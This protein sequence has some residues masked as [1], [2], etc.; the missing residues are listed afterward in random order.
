MLHCVKSRHCDLGESTLE[1]ITRLITTNPLSMPR[2]VPTS[3]SSPSSPRSSSSGMD[4][5]LVHHAESGRHGSIERSL[6]HNPPRA[7]SL[8]AQVRQD[9]DPGQLC[10]WPQQWLQSGFDRYTDQIANETF[11]SYN[12]GPHQ[13]TLVPPRYRWTQYDCNVNDLLEYE[14]TLRPNGFSRGQPF[15]ARADHWREMNAPSPSPSTRMYATPIHPC[16]PLS[17]SI[18]SDSA[19]VGDDEDEDGIDD[20]D[21]IDEDGIPLPQDLAQNHN[22]GGN[23]RRHRRPWTEPESLWLLQCV[24]R[25]TQEIEAEVFR[26]AVRGKNWNRIAQMVGNGRTPT[27][28]SNKYHKLMRETRDQVYTSG[29][30]TNQPGRV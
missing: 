25:H 22:R 15:P 21:A 20:D 19:Y 13:H 24:E 7:F 18:Q 11:R 5:E 3:S 12:V 30:S 27:S 6:L 1:A 4:D 29:S 28:C 2:S 23:G 10:V 14:D 8:V 17:I 9:L 26:F 16:S